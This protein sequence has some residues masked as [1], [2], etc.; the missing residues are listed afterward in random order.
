MKK[1][2]GGSRP[3]PRP[4]PRT[5]TK[6]RS[7]GAKG[8]GQ[9]AQ[10]YK[11]RVRGIRGIR[12]QKILAEAGVA[13]RRECEELILAGRVTV[14]GVT[15]DSLPAWVDPKQ[16]LVAVDGERVSTID[17]GKGTGSYVYV[18]LNKPR[19]VVS[20]TSDPQG[21]RC[22]T[23]L[24]DLPEHLSARLYP[25]GRLDA[26]ST[27]LILLTNDGPLTQLLTHPS[28]EVPKRYHVW[29][30]GRV[31]PED[32]EKLSK[33]LMLVAKRV[34]PGRMSGTISDKSS[35][36]GQKD[37]PGLPGAGVKRAR[38][39]QVTI[40]GY[41][42]GRDNTHHTRLSVVLRE[43]QNRQ[44]RRM[45]ARLGYKVRRLQRISIGP[46]KLKGLA[47]GQWRLLTHGE[48]RALKKWSAG[49]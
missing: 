15:V 19:K 29:V 9:A 8:S 5:G 37:L 1:Q 28:H 24:V 46:I 10:Q 49:R 26:D 45:L 38:A 39:A 30:R 22:V 11:Q 6:R 12:L 36:M 25:V 33:G 44:I 21:R 7:G 14:N 13:S 23:D 32:L 40:A 43:G 3:D 47:L 4:S 27:G 31:T 18:I 35:A 20:T 34:R 41:E 2:K 48:I 42:R 17:R 16:D